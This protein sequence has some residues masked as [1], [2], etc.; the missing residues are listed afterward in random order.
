MSS[1][2]KTRSKYLDLKY[3]DSLEYKASEKLYM[4]SKNG[5]IEIVKDSFRAGANINWANPKESQLTSLSVASD[6]GHKNIV[7]F[8]LKYGADV[9]KASIR[10]ETPLYL[11]AHK[12]YATIVDLLL[13]RRANI[14]TADENGLSP[15]HMATAANHAEIVKMLLE[16]GADVNASDNQG[17]TPLYVAAKWNMTDIVKILLTHGATLN[18]KSTDELKEIIKN[19]TKP[20]LTL[21]LPQLI[22]HQQLDANS[23]KEFSK[24]YS[25]YHAGGKTRRKMRKMRKTQR[26]RK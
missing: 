9:N 13:K 24:D 18:M 17:K 11:A 2:G 6:G 16:H 23:F 20:M 1:P 12:G 8:L 7:E 3:E 26:N 19:W 4:G 10:N 14:N 25:Q 21:V 5:K 15:L 22:M